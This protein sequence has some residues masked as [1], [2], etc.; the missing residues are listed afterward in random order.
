MRSTKRH[1]LDDEDVLGFKEQRGK[2]SRTRALK[3]KRE[4][5]KLAYS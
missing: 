2:F 4:L 1:W 5:R 3:V